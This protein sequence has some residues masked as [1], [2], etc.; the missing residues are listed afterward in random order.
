[1]QASA[2]FRGWRIVAAAFVGQLVAAACTFSTFGVFVVPLAQ[3]FETTRGQISAGYGAALLMMG[4]VGPLLGRAIDRGPLRGLMLAGVGLVAAGLL[5]LARATALWQ[6]GAI[7]LVVVLGS[8]MFGVLPSTALVANWFVRR[9]GLALGV[10]VS[11]ATAAGFA[12]PPLAAFLIDAI[13]WRGALASLG[14]GSAAL[15]GPVFF[16]LVVRR[17]EDVGQAPDGDPV[18][19]HTH[20]HAHSLAAVETAALLRDRNLWLLALAF[21]LVLSTPIVMGLHLV[22]YAEDLG[23]TRQSAAWFFSCLAPSSLLGKLA[24]GVVADRIDAR[25]ALWIAVAILASSWALLLTRP[26]YPAFL[27]IAVLYGFGAGASAPIHGVLVGACF[28]RDAFGRVMGIGSLAGLPLIALSGPLTGY[29]Y[30]ATG[31]Y[32]AGFTLQAAWLV[33]AALLLTLLRIPR[34]VPEGG[35]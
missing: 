15:A 34:R 31:S 28:G 23:F 10:A 32:R 5:L 27:A 25:R 8:A 35:L 6:M 7:Y 17:P 18:H 33:A 12:V 4:F 13:G 22:P 26:G 21:G 3:E 20:G 30:D 19:P 9:R 2:P 11:G 29:L 14:I 24:F 16:A 1:V